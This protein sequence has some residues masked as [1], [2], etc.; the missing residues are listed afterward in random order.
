MVGPASVREA[1]IYMPRL[2]SS[3]RATDMPATTWLRRSGL[4]LAALL[5][6][7]VSP[8]LAQA[9]KATPPE[10]SARIRL[11]L[12]LLADPEVKRWIEHQSEAEK[13]KKP[14][15]AKDAGVADTVSVRLEELRRGMTA[16][17]AAIPTM[18][19]E[20]ARAVDR[21]RRDMSGDGLLR[22]I[23]L[24]VGFLAIGALTE[25]FLL[26]ATRGA[27]RA[28]SPI[29]PGSVQER[30]RTVAVRL[31]S[32]LIRQ[33]AF[34]IGSVGAFLVF[35][36][37]P[38]L[39][40][41]VLAYLLAFV[42]L[43]LVAVLARVL[44][45]PDNDQAR[46][47]P[48]DRE[49]ASY[50]YRRI[51]ALTAWF[52]VG[53]ATV[54]S[55]RLLGVSIPAG[56]VFGL[57]LAIGLLVIGVEM[58][59]Q[60]PRPVGIA[61]QPTAGRHKVSWLLTLFFVVLWALRV[62]GLFPTFWLVLVV[63]AVPAAIALT[64][65]AVDHLLRP[66]ENAAADLP[67]ISN[68]YR[69]GLE[70]GLRA[71]WIVGA[72][73]LLA[74]VWGVDLV[75]MTASDSVGTRLLRG[76]LSAVVIMLVA[77]LGW[78]M[79]RVLIDD[80]LVAAHQATMPNTDEARRRA[81]ARTLLPIVKNV[82]F[83]VLLVMAVLMALAS[84]GIEIGPLIAGAGVVGVAIGFG[85]QTLVKD[86]ISGM[87]YLMDDAFRV[88]EYIQSGSYKGTVESFSLRSVKLRHQRGPVYTVPFGVLGAIQNMSRDWVIEKMMIG[89]T[90][91]SDIDVA[92]KLIKQVGKD[93]A[94]IPEFTS[95][96]LE[97][98]KMQ[99]VENFGDYAIQIR[100][101][102]KTRPGEQFMIKRRAFAMIKKTFDEHGIKFAYPT[103]Q[104]AGGEAPA[105]AAQAALKAAQAPA[106]AS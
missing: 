52:A 86:V 43:R 95:S 49:S 38:L 33:L 64:R 56:R 65:R 80:R 63:V 89:I 19:A 14:A 15:P 62:F 16:L 20:L 45:A 61:A 4:W 47:L 106:A 42:A 50:W 54:E 31:G 10:E 36:W 81:R 57:T 98:L 72:A 87:F 88:G 67:P 105:A 30:L 6:L 40:Q 68:L 100:L 60:R 27:L 90:Y 12:D 79:L 53:L 48:L 18:P 92:K 91:D 32:G 71:T 9:P 82:M 96:I 8:V 73:L 103:V 94:A 102:M 34:A 66:P 44:L 78:Q 22:A 13:A 74:H 97:P 59:W 84:L 1:D 93:L 29:V 24:V 69:V 58:V 25:W 26:L 55:A 51:L 37:P 39:R 5:W 76:A 23:L 2:M 77:D 83:I 85:A 35:D 101:K 17:V 70:R 41:I 21:L 3:E 11:L 104:V 75:A 99:G 46:V 7:V 28:S